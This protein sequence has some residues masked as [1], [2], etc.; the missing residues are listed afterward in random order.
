M[1]VS[2]LPTQELYKL[3]TCG[4][5]VQLLKL[6]WLT[7]STIPMETVADL[8]FCEVFAGKSTI[9][10]GFVCMGRTAGFAYDVKFNK[11][12]HV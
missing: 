12:P 7:R 5:P 6:I 10:N 2:M 1:Y 4:V 8:E 3:F 11:V 9:V